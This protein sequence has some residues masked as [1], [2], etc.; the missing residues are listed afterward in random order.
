MV[1]YAQHSPPLSHPNKWNACMAF[2]RP[3]VR[4][5][6]FKTLMHVIVT[7]IKCTWKLWF[8]SNVAVALLLSVP[9]CPKCRANKCVH[10]RV[11]GNISHR[12]RQA[13]TRNGIFPWNRKSHRGRR[14]ADNRCR[15]SGGNSCT[16]FAKNITFAHYGATRDELASSHSCNW[17]KHEM[18]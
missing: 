11:F 17:N 18:H 3:N 14:T 16:L 10:V 2:I 1:V 9:L 12:G 6:P 13:G 8:V 7:R 4:W 15:A 5:L